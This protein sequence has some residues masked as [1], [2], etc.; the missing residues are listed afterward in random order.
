MASKLLALF[1]LILVIFGCGGGGGGVGGT[2]ATLVGRVLD[3][4]NGG[5]I[6]PVATVQ[7]GGQS[8][9]TQAD[10]SFQLTVASGTTSVTVDAGT[11]GAF[12]FTVPAASGTTDVGDLWV[13]PQKVTVTGR[14]LDSTNGTAVE[15]ATVTFAGRRATTNSVGTYRLE[16]VAYSN[17]SQAAFWGIV[18]KVR[19]VDYF[20]VSFTASGKTAVSGTVTLDEIRMT[21]SDGTNPPPFPFTI[22][23]T[24][25][26]T[27]DATGT[28]VTL[29]EAGTAVRVY[30]VGSDGAY[31]FWV[32]PG[33]YT[34]EARKGALADDETATLTQTNEVV[35]R[36]INLQ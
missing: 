28:V 35:R 21:P 9:Q 31:Y 32:V 22:W 17:T 14:V 36:D 34:I 4:R 27:A 26:P 13:G 10:G 16:N 15:G 20:D 7:S 8:V 33:T 29:K 5:P 19:A 30:N 23:G 6:S 24:V 2:N 3:V 18:G 12:T 1:V 11:F 25:S